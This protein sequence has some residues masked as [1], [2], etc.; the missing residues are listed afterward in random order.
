MTVMTSFGDKICS[1]SHISEC[2]SIHTMVYD[3]P[4]TFAVAD[5]PVAD[6]QDASLILVAGEGNNPPWISFTDNFS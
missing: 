6:E 2:D 3:S 1:R 4:I 5:E